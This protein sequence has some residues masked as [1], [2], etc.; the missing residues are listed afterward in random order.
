MLIP[1]AG[2]IVP[3]DRCHGSEVKIISYTAT[4]R[5]LID[6]IIY[7]STKIVYFLYWKGQ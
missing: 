3:A 2:L 6:I 1:I 4:L 7:K 5:A